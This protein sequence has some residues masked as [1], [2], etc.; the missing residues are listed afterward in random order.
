MH[1]SSLFS[2]VKSPIVCTWKMSASHTR[3]DYATAESERMKD[4]QRL[5][6]SRCCAELLSTTVFGVRYAAKRPKVCHGIPRQGDKGVSPRREKVPSLLVTPWQAW[7]KK[8]HPRSPPLH[9]FWLPDQL[10]LLFLLDRP[11][12]RGACCL[13]SQT[14]ATCPHAHGT[15]SCTPVLVTPFLA[16]LI[17]SNQTPWH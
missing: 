9:S 4:H 13:S 8:G 14:S 12:T 6:S 16:K 1:Y 7:P 2:V 10:F 17:C 3:R 15:S 5:S 11:Q